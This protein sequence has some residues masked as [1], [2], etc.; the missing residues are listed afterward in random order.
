MSTPAAPDFTAYVSQNPTLTYGTAAGAYGVLH[1]GA[2]GA[3]TLTEAKIGIGGRLD[4]EYLLQTIARPGE[5]NSVTL[6]LTGTYRDSEDPLVIWLWT[7]S[8]WSDITAAA[9]NQAYRAPLGC[10]DANG[11]IRVRFTDSVNVRSEPMGSLAL[12][13]LYAAVT[14]GELPPNQL[15]VAQDDAASTPADTAISITVLANDQDPDGD[16]LTVTA[17]SS[18]ANGTVTLNADQT[19]GDVPVSGFTGMDSFTYT[20]SD[21][22]AGSATA[23]V[24]VTVTPAGPSATVVVGGINLSAALAGKSWKATADVRIIDQTGAAAAGAT[25]FNDSPLQ[26]GGMATTDAAGLAVLTSP[27]VKTSG[28]TFT[29]RV[30]N[31]VL[32]GHAF[33]GGGDP[34]SIQ[35]P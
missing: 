10:V 30:T 29:F 8:A 5:I 35:V 16:P 14:V 1:P 25:V 32:A 7:G 31:V 4:A 18:A 23:T 27:P 34:V 33:A 21:P 28:G 24:T 20:V 15:P 3:Q 11:L 26:T 2:A 12:A 9:F 22:Y 13:E 19:V 6:G 17:V